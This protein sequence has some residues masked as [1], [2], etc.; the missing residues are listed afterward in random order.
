LEGLRRTDDDDDDDD[1]E[2]YR[3]KVEGSA[4]AKDIPITINAQRGPWL[5]L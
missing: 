4:V 3:W 2:I 1:G 5:L